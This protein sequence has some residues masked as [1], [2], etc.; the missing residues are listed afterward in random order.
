MYLYRCSPGCVEGKKGKIGPNSE[1][2]HN[3]MAASCQQD[4]P[5]KAAA[6]PFEEHA[7]FSQDECCR[8]LQKSLARQVPRDF[9]LLCKAVPPICS[10]PSHLF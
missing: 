10:A 3:G 6:L 8:Q 2:Q 7:E 9:L 1:P 5:C 4:L